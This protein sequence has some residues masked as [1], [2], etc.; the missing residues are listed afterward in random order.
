MKHIRTLC[1]SFRNALRG[2][3]MTAR[4]ERN[5]RIEI[6]IA[7]VV[8]FGVSVAPLSMTDRVGAWIVVFIVLIAE[9][10]NTAIEH[11]V[12]CATQEHSIVARAA[13][14]AAAGA[15]LFAGFGACIY[16]GFLLWRIGTHIL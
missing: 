16:G 9:L 5:F 7:V 4:T 1:H 3:T 12:D 8:L 10:F 15:V 11:A 14:D 2:I 13:K 6:V